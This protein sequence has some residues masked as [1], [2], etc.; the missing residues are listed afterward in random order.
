MTYLGRDECSGVRSLPVTRV[1]PKLGPS[2]CFSLCEDP[3]LGSALCPAEDFAGTA[4]SHRPLTDSKTTLGRAEGDLSLDPLDVPA[5][6]ES[7]ALQ[8]LQPYMPNSCLHI[9]LWQL[10][11]KLQ[12][13]LMV[14]CDLGDLTS[15]LFASVYPTLLCNDLTEGGW[16]GVPF[17]MSSQ[18]KSP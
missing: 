15:L 4:S 13:L 14:C 17:R 12:V 6:D 2:G 9:A 7:P 3:A 5:A 8:A 10:L 1:M 18:L 16:K 11:V